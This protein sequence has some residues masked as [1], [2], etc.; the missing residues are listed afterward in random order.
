MEIVIVDF[1]KK[2]L[3][4]LRCLKSVSGTLV[5]KTLKKIHLIV[6]LARHIVYF[7]DLKIASMRTEVIKIKMRIVG[8]V[9]L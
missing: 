4:N 7:V 2:Y 3:L 5:N 9:G 1:L 6:N 8:W